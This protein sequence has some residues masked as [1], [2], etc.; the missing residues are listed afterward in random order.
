MILVYQHRRNDINEVFYVGIGRGNRPYSRSGRNSHWRNVVNKAGY[1]VEIL[2]SF[3]SWEDACKEEKR[4]IAEY[5]RVDREQGA[6]VNK[7][8]GGDGTLGMRHSE[9]AR[10]SMSNKR[11][12]RKLSNY[13]KQRISEGLS[14][15]TKSKEHRASLAKS[16]LGKSLPPLSKEHKDKIV[17]S[18]LGKKRNDV[19]ERNKSRQNPIEGRIFITNGTQNKMIYPNDPIPTGWYKGVKKAQN[20][21]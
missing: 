21:I 7:T 4:L 17:K 11:K 12:G 2:Q 18:K 16:K 14:G 9:T 13:Q 10:K 1:T 5:G 6:L 15:K 8:D 3:E 20:K 19:A